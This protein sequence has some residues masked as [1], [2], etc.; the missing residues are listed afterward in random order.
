MEPTCLFK[1]KPYPACRCGDSRLAMKTNHNFLSKCGQCK[2][3]WRGPLC[4]NCGFHCCLHC[5][6]QNQNHWKT[7]VSKLSHW[8]D[9][10]LKQQQE[11]KKTL[12]LIPQIFILYNNKELVKTLCSY[13]YNTRN[14][15]IMS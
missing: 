10:A 1:N 9:N 11:F 3:K 7:T 5:R 14:K 6:K 15:E 8:N 4:S 12:Q 13:I 2:N